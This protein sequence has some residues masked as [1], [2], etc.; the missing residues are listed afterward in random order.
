ML[1]VIGIRAGARNGAGAPSKSRVRQRRLARPV[2]P[3]E[4]GEPSRKVDLDVPVAADRNRRTLTRLKCIHFV[5]ASS[6]GQPA[7]DLTR[8]SGRATSPAGPDYSEE[9]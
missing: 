3:D 7:L 8:R 9:G 1:E 6:S 4:H 5:P 2:R